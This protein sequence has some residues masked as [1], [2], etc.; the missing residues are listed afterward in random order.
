MWIGDTFSGRSHTWDDLAFLRKNWDGPIVLK[1]IQHVDDAK[2]AYEN[3]CDGIIVS[4][5]GGKSAFTLPFDHQIAFAH[6]TT[7]GRQVDGAIGALEVLPEIVDAVGDK[8][9]VLFDSGIRTGVDIIKALCLGAQAVLVGRPVIYGL[10]IDGKNGAKSVMRGLLADLW[11][12][13]GLAG[14]RTT[15]E[16][17]RSCIRKVQY[18]G[19][20]KSMM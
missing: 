7:A 20:L 15:A 3:G 2:L 1:G 6:T 14:M 17:N 19:D 4:N 16:C 5:H 10:S 11:Q 8:M 13:M 12:S 18:P 9:N